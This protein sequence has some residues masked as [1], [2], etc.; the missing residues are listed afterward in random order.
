MHSALRINDPRIDRYG[1]A[2]LDV[3]LARAYLVVFA[4]SDSVC[5]SLI[6]YAVEGVVCELVVVTN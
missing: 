1:Y 5:Y 3:Q 2:N 6:R 4:S